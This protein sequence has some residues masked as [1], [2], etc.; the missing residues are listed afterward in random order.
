MRAVSAERGYLGDKVLVTWI[1][2]GDDGKDVPVVFLHDVEDDRSLLLDGRP[3]LKEHGVVVL[4]KKKQKNR[5]Q[6]NK[7]EPRMCTV[8]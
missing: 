2:R 3:E 8:A 4:G 7:D 5:G 6:K 1:V